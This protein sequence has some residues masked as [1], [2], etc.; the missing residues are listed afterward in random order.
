MP[1][2]DIR[3][4]GTIVDN[5]I[6]LQLTELET[7][8]AIRLQYAV[9]VLTLRPQPS[10]EH[11]AADRVATELAEAITPL[12]RST[13]LIGL[14]GTAGR[15]RVLLL[16]SDLEQLGGIIR[17]IL[18]EVRLHAFQGAPLRLSIG[19]ACFPDTAASSNELL[20]QADALAED[21]GQ[22]T[23][24]YSRYRLAGRRRRDGS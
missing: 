18:A 21:V 24:S 23:A 5:E 13:D 6:F 1:R 22:D 10:G 8:H 15:V 3:P 16:G 17:R 12:I 9:C 2:W 11:V 19:G 14:V 20:G 7:R 4:H